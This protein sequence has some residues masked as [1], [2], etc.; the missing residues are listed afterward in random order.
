MVQRY[1]LNDSEVLIA[2]YLVVVVV[3][4]VE[5][6]LVAVMKSAMNGV[7]VHRWNIPSMDSRPIGSNIAAMR[8]MVG[9]PGGTYHLWKSL[10]SMDGGDP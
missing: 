7:A 9:Y 3:V 6:V 10:L 1:I 8:C 5:V 4:V 2:G